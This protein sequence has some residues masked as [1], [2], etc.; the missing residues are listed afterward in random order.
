MWEVDRK[1]R[2]YGKAGIFGVKFE[3]SSVKRYAIL[4]IYGNLSK[5]KRIEWKILFHSHDIS[6]CRMGEQE[7]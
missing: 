7:S 5:V 3:W 2:L 6:I 4:F 1:D